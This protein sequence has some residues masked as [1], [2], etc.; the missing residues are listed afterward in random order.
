[1]IFTFSKECS[2]NFI[3][4]ISL[5]YYF[6]YKIN[7]NFTFNYFSISSILFHSNNIIIRLR[8]TQR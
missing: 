3:C 2:V 5:T 1:M 6:T 7:F 8:S 4:A